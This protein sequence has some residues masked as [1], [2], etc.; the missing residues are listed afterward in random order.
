MGITLMVQRSL[1]VGRFYV[2]LEKQA[3]DGLM[4]CGI[5]MFYCTFRA[6]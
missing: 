1:V 6:L 2:L 3:K 4:K 5:S